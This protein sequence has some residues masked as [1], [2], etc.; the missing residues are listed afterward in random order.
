MRKQRLLAMLAASA[1]AL[2]GCSALLDREYVQVIPHNTAPTAEGDPNVLRADSYQEL[3]NI[4]LYF[5]TTGAEK[6][7]VRLYLN[8]EAVES[9]LEAACLEVVQ[10]D[11]LG[12]YAVEF[13]KY[14]VNSLV[15]YFEAEVQITYRR[16]REQVASIVS[17]TG[18]TAIRSEL[19]SA[20]AVF[21]PERVLRISYFDGDEDF[22][23]TLVRQ[24]Y[25]AS[26]AS[27][28][29]MPEIAVSI[30]PEAGRQRIVEILL[31][32]H[33]DPQE[34]EQRKEKVG[35]Q[36]RL[37]S[38]PLQLLAGDEAVQ[39]IARTLLKESRYDPEAGSTAYHALTEG[40]ADS[41]GLALAFAALCDERGIPCQVVEGVLED[42]PWYWNVVSTEQGWRHLDLT[43]W[44]LLVQEGEDPFRTDPDM[45]ERG[46]MWDTSSVPLCPPAA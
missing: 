29:D 41:E 9:S 44:E 36:L 24:A 19:R 18:V 16:T 27:A 4:L 28:L 13:I 46:L 45:S 1:L 39:A 6:G 31:T 12:A 32:Y 35:Q 30:Y 43:R 25:Y 8:S 14:S 38:R 11:P 26:P 42:N 33:L 3:V 34:L 15:T 7:L 23:Q 2:S 22:I 40:A 37:L 10:E 21:A 5:V 20:L 17:A